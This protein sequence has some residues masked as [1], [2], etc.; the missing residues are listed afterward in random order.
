MEYNLIS[1]LRVVSAK[2]AVPEQPPA[3]VNATKI[4][5][6]KAIERRMV[7]EQE[8]LAIIKCGWLIVVAFVA[9]LIP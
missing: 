4:K 3:L 5:T 7:I 8:R 1:A 9:L 6:T 2:V